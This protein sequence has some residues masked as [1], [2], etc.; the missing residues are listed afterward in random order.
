[1]QQPQTILTACRWRQASAAAAAAGK[2]GC[3]GR[4]CRRRGGCRACCCSRACNSLANAD[5]HTN[6][7]MHAEI[8]CEVLACIRGVPC[9]EESLGTVWEPR[10]LALCGRISKARHGAKSGGTNPHGNAQSFSKAQ[11]SLS[12]VHF[13]G[14][15]ARYHGRR[16]RAGHP[17]SRRRL[18]HVRHKCALPT[19]G[20][21]AAHERMHCIEPVLTSLT[22]SL[23]ST[24]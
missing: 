23:H 1:M 6:R 19:D 2:P 18:T 16:R 12:D 10:S 20:A 22:E 4:P 14:S 3:R 13:T 24:T 9:A 15:S 8:K 17:G 21:C 7:C 11:T 5:P